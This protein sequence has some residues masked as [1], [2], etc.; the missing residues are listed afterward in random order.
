[1][2]DVVEG[3]DIAAGTVAVGATPVAGATITPTRTAALRLT[4]AYS[5]DDTL[6]VIRDGDTALA[7]GGGTTLGVNQVNTFVMGV[8]RGSTYTFQFAGGGTIRILQ[9][10]VVQGGVI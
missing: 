8:V 3:F 10:E 9:G 5:A 7:F 6:Q 1:M 2:T 4:V